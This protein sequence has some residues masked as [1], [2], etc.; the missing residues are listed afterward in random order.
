MI[1]V[2]KIAAKDYQFFEIILLQKAEVTT[3]KYKRN[4][5]K[6]TEGK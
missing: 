6:G 4:L 1:P 5:E 3:K 2:Y